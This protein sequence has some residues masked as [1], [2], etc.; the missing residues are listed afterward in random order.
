MEDFRD[1][2]ML[3]TPS[4]SCTPPTMPAGVDMHSDRSEEMLIDLVFSSSFN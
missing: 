4:N 2:G 1:A 3:N